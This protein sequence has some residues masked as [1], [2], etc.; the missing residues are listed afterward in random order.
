[1]PKCLNCN[2][3]FVKKYKNQMGKFRFCM[4]KAA[5][6]TAF[7]EAYKESERAKSNKNKQ[8]IKQAKQER[9]TGKQK[10]YLRDDIQKLARMIDEKFG[11]GCCCCNNKIEGTGHG[12]HYHNKG[13]NENIMFNLDNIHRSRAHCN[14]FSSEHK[15]GYKEEMKRRYGDWYVD[16]LEDQIRLKYKEMHFSSDQITKALK[17]TRSIIRN[18]NTFN[19]HDSLE[20]RC[21]FNNT[22]GLYE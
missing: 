10:N 8:V 11:F 5:C 18:F 1:M 21:I 3:K 13:G 22:I 4:N 7:N 14:M 20:A 12:A 15:K 17:T 2:E 6:I 9:K 19:L 16:Y